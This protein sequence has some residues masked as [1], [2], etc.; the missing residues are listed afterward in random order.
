MCLQAPPKG[1][2]QPYDPSYFDEFAAP[3][4]GGFISSESRSSKGLPRG[5]VAPV[6]PMRGGMRGGRW[7]VNLYVCVCEIVCVSQ[8]VCVTMCMCVCHNVYVCVTMCVCVSV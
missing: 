2:I 4:Y 1:P 6:P 5:S 8:C 7:V 3:E